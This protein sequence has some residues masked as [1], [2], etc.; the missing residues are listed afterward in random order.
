MKYIKK[1]SASYQGDTPIATSIT[2]SSTNDEVA[3]AKAVYDY[4]QTQLI[5]FYNSSLWSNPQANVYNPVTITTNAQYGSN[6]KIEDNKIYCLKDVTFLY[7]LNCSLQQGATNSNKFFRLRKN[8]NTDIFT[9]LQ[10]SS[11]NVAVYNASAILVSGTT[12][13][14]FEV[15]FYGNSTAD[16]IDQARFNCTFLVVNSLAPTPS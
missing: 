1:V 14:Y 2:S 16:K 4:G 15:C 13:D 7:Y 3:G 10:A 12:G 5:S 11:G 6:F 9:I 8:G